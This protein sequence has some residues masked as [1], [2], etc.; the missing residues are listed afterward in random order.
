VMGTT[1][2]GVGNWLAIAGFISVSLVVVETF[3]WVVRRR[4]HAV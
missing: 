4:S 2:L 3:K 1:P